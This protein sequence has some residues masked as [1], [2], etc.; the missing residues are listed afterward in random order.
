MNARTALSLLSPALFLACAP[1]L[2][3]PRTPAVLR[4]TISTQ[5]P[6]VRR[7]VAGPVSL[8]AYA[9]FGRAHLFLAEDCRQLSEASPSQ[10]IVADRR[11]AVEVPAGQVACLATDSRRSFELLWRAVPRG[12]EAPALASRSER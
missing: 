12:D 1:G 8:R 2:A 9:G 3:Q 4:G 7:I 10:P 5:A 11:L 6:A